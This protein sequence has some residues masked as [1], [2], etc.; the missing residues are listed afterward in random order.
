MLSFLA[1][2]DVIVGAANGTLNVKLAE[3]EPTGLNPALPDL[4]AVT[5][6]VVADVALSMLPLTEQPA[7]LTWKVTSPVPDPPEVVREIGV[8]VKPVNTEFV[9][10][11]GA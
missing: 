7:P 5:L 4:I 11:S 10:E 2:V 1:K 6:H 9:T 8:P 3:P